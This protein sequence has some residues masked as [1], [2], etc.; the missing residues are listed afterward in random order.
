MTSLAAVAGLDLPRSFVACL[1]FGIDAYHGVNHVQVLENIA[2]L[3]RDA[4]YL[5]AFSVPGAS[6]EAQLYRGRGRRLK[7]TA[8]PTNRG[9][10][11]IH[12]HRRLALSRR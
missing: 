1:G 2:A 9:C 4:A 11:R 12:E 10:R 6:R 3:D 8:S 7:P 5:G